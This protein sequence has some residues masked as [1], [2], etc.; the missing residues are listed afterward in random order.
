MTSDQKSLSGG[1]LALMSLVMVVVPEKLS[2]P[3]RPII[4]TIPIVPEVYAS[5]GQRQ[6]KL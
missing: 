5:R 1:R 6:S 4:G 3:K 2:G